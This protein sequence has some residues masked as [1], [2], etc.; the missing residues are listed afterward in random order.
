MRWRRRLQT[1]SDEQ[2]EK[3]AQG[4]EDADQGGGDP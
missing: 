3:D 2:R 1:V 4:G